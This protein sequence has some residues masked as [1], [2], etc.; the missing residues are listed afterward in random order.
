[1]VVDNCFCFDLRS[2]SLII[3]WLDLLCEIILAT[4][5]HYAFTLM[6]IV[7]AFALYGIYQVNLNLISCKMF[8]II[9]LCVILSIAQTSLF[10]ATNAGPIGGNYIF[11]VVWNIHIRRN[12]YLFVRTC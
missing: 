2:G 5:Q 3:I 4:H 11:N 6:L 10:V 9:S 8:A 7:P 12:N 1:M